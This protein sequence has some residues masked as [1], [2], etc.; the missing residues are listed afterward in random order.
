MWLVLTA[1]VPPSLN[2][3]RAASMIRFLVSADR[4]CRCLIVVSMV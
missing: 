1:A 2:S 4:F 3:R